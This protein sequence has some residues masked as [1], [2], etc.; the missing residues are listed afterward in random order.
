MKETG[1]HPDAVEFSL[2]KTLQRILRGLIQTI[3]KILQWTFLIVVGLSLISALYNLTLPRKSK[4]VGLLSM[5]EKSL[6]AEA[7]HLQKTLGNEVWPGWGDAF[8]PRMVYNETYAFLLGYP[9][10]PAGWVKMPKEEVRGTDWEVVQTD[11]FFSETYYRQFLPNPAITPENFTV[12]V[13][14]QWV[15]TMQTKEYAA[16]A[17]YQGLHQE[18]PPVL[19]SIFPYSL[20]WRTLMGRPENY[21]VGLMHE[22]FHAFQGTQAPQRLADAESVAGLEKDYPWDEPSN[23]EGWIVEIDFLMKA[24][25]AENNVSALQSVQ[26]FLIKRSERRKKAGLS[27]EMISYEQKREWLEG[28]AK[29]AELTLGLKASQSETYKNAQEIESVSSFKHYKTFP[30]FYRLQVN[31]VKRM[32]RHSGESRFYYTGMLQALMLDRLM[33]DWKKEAFGEGIWLDDL[34]RKAVSFPSDK[35]I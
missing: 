13:G 4:I 14:P 17:F 28:L 18:L 24:L 10:P 7:M 34:L 8:T 29:Y 3:K 11:D 12:K 19:N 32:S 31:E 21:I 25:H 23:A 22:S 9:D 1:H 16:I 5:Q 20:F 2:K 15:S 35:A 6:I 26:Q 33:P 30:R 27:V